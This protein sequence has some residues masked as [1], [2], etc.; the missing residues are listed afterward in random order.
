MARSMV[1]PN[2]TA[3]RPSASTLVLQVAF[4]WEKGQA[5]APT[6]AGP[7]GLRFDAPHPRSAR[8]VV[9]DLQ[10]AQESVDAVVVD[11][12]VREAEAVRQETVESASGRILP[13]LR[14]PGSADV[15]A[16]V[17]A[18]PAE[19]RNWRRRRL[20][21]WDDLRSAAPADPAAITTATAVPA[22]K[23]FR[24]TIPLFPKAVPSVHGHARVGCSGNNTSQ[25]KI[26]NG[27]SACAA[28][29]PAES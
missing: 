11:R 10:T 17:P 24:M 23:S 20:V 2:R 27:N 19:D 6:N 8:N 25:W 1:P 18:G 28:H 16:D 5:S 9:T 12:R 4:S 21:N 29:S 15:H 26:R 7:A 22:S 13:L 3:K 14:P